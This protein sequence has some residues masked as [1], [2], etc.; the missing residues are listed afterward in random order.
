MRY[1]IVLLGTICHL[2][3]GLSTVDCSTNS[4]GWVFVAR[5]ESQATNNDN[6]SNNNNTVKYSVFRQ[7]NLGVEQ[8]TDAVNNGE[9]K[10][11]FPCKNEIEKRKTKKRTFAGT[12]AT[13]AGVIGSETKGV[14]HHALYWITALDAIESFR[15]NEYRQNPLI[16]LCSRST[17]MA[18]NS[19]GVVPSMYK[20]LFYFAK[21]RPRL[22]FSVGSSLRALQLCT[23]LKNLIDPS[24]GV[25]A[26]INILA[27][28]CE[29]RWMHP[30]ILGWVCTKRF[31]VWMGAK[32]IHGAHLSL[33]LLEGNHVP[34]SL[35][36]NSTAL[37]A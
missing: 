32:P 2:L 27:I 21:L 28:L 13:A 11:V 17:C 18:S 15:V 4:N 35:H 3:F 16:S 33:S 10:A 14:V 30:I 25:G 6:N 1:Q 12:V 24:I 9:K 20:K 5:Q 7:W 31:W 22:L 29:N 34:I 19:C 8:K 36:R 37:I 23:P 26:G